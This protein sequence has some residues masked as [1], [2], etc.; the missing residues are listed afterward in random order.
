MIDFISRLADS[1]NSIDGL[2][3]KAKTDYITETDSLGIYALP[4]GRTIQSDMLGNRDIERIFEIVI[5]T[6]DNQLASQTLE[7]IYDH[8]SQDDIQIT[9]TNDSYEFEK[10]AL[11]EPSLNDRDEDGYYIVLLDVTATLYIE[12]RN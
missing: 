10:L 11:T 8:L 4:G 3:F 5:K 7:L 2:P 12:K 6:K 9:S 1:V